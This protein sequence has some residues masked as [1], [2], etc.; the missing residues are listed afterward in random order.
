MRADATTS[1][2][3][4]QSKKVG[5]LPKQSSAD[6]GGIQNVRGGDQTHK[7]HLF[8]PPT[9]AGIRPVKKVDKGSMIHFA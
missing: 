3:A 4:W 9:A 8:I 5:Q 2:S 1:M 6:T 7:N